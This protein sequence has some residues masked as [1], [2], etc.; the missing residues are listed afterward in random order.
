MKKN[1]CPQCDSNSTLVRCPN[2]LE[3]RK[4]HFNVIEHYFQC[5]KCR[6]EFTN[7]ELDDLTLNQVYNQYRVKHDI[8]FPE[9]IRKIRKQ[10]GLSYSKMSEILGFGVN[11][12]RNY[13][14]GEMPSQGN[15]NLIRCAKD[16]H[17]FKSLVNE[18]L[19]SKNTLDQIYSKVDLLIEE[20]IKKQKALCR[21]VDINNKPSEYTGFRSL[22]LD[23]V[24]NIVLFLINN[25]L[26]KYAG[27]LKINKLLFYC[28]FLHFKRFA[29]SLTGLTYRIIQYGPVPSF[30]DNLYS[31]L[32]HQNFIEEEFTKENSYGI[33]KTL[34]EVE[35][36]YFSNDEI[37]TLEK[38]V[39][40]FRNVSPWDLVEISH[41]EVFFEPLVTDKRLV[42]YMEYGFKL[43]AL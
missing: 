15:A 43:K 11:S 26:D 29:I 27:K 41:K 1:A 22:D 2:E 33:Y 19:F 6:E 39:D 16:P 13:E 25:T 36:E 32:I 5:N 3:F 38:V 14:K 17:T 7:T 10:Y 23:R 40:C 8:P 12:Y 21:I 35:K 9:E 42:N 18:N 28:D 34:E 31:E 30:Y 20:N 37:Q 24:K 4:E